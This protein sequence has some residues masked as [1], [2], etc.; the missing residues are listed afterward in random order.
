M[1]LVRTRDFLKVFVTV[2]DGDTDVQHAQTIF[3]ID[4]RNASYASTECGKRN[5]GFYHWTRAKS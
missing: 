1:L 5:S 2:I 4:G 3:H